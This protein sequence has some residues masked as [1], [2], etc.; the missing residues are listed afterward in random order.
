MP[1][2]F[3]CLMARKKQKKF[4]HCFS[5]RALRL[6][7][8]P[9]WRLFLRLGGIEI[10]A[11]QSIISEFREFLKFRKRYWLLPIVLALFLFC[12]LIIFTKSS[13]VAPF[14]YALFLTFCWKI[15]HPL[16]RRK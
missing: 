11:N 9:F 2:L 15:E 14:I 5:S 8:R 10:M 4:F 12:A 6:C 13:A 16:R 1:A 3:E 7:A